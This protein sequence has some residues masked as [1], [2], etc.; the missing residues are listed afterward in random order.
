MDIDLKEKIPSQGSV[1]T[2]PVLG[3]ASAFSLAAASCCLLPVGL[4]IIGFGGS[5]LTLLGPFV[6]YRSFILV[7]VGVVLAAA[8]ISLLSHHNR[9]ARR[10]G[11]GLAVA[12][13]CSIIFLAAVS[14]P[15][16]EDEAVRSLWFYWME[17]S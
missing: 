3:I 4:S 9:C 5:W 1:W 11:T 16:W 6:A 12:I 10:K 13:G 2:A 7:G 15:F 17:S 14:A 8:W